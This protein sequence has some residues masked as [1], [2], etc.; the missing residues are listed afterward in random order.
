MFSLFSF[1]SALFSLKIYYNFTFF[2][3]FLNFFI[4]LCNVSV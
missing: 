1:F 4:P 2:V 3:D